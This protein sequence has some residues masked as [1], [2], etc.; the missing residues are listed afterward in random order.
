M[1]SSQHPVALTVERRVGGA[2]K[3]LATI[4]CLPLVDGIFPALVLAGALGDP[5]GILE[6]GLLIFGG[7]ATVAVVL[8]EMDGSRREVAT[9]I[10]AVGAV[11]IPV[12]AVEAALAPTIRDMLNMP[13]FSRFA[14]LVILTVAAKTASARIG[15]YLPRPAVV[16]ALG[17]VASFDPSGVSLSVTTDPEL[18][19]RAVAAAGVGV[20]FALFVALSG[21][22]LRAVVDIDRFRFGSAVALGV[23]PLSIF[24]LVPG[25]APIALAVLGVTALFAFDPGGDR[26][27]D[28]VPGDASDDAA[29]ADGGDPE[30]GSEEA[31][32]DDEESVPGR[33]S[34]YVTSD[35]ERAPWL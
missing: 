31:A 26:D 34:D 30:D 29:V 13:V 21:P 14:G 3:L 17:L 19:G 23:L 11:L 9:A 33:V 28:G 15:E 27:Y 12:A 32:E 24:G 2:T 5:I 22:W 16:I 4:M 10:L 35:D 8:A 6:V 7:S 1:S 20:G 18:I 25:D